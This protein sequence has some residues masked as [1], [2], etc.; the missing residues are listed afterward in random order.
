MKKVILIILG[1]LTSLFQYQV[2]AQKFSK[3]DDIIQSLMNEITLE[4]GEK[5]DTSAIR[6]LF[7]P[8]ATLAVLMPGKE[9]KLESITIDNFLEMLI[10][11]YYEEGYLEMEL[12]KEVQEFN[13]IAQ[14]FQ[15]FLWRRL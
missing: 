13:G 14:V 3:I 6:N 1:L 12:H 2:S 11:P 5:M 8:H 4:K 10:D 15:S 9:A 7:E